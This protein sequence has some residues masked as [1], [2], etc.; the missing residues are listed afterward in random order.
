M[1]TALGTRGQP[2]GQR[3]NRAGSNLAAH[4][5]AAEVAFGENPGAQR[6]PGSQDSGVA[7][8]TSSRARL[9]VSGALPCRTA[10]TRPGEP[11]VVTDRGQFTESLFCA[12]GREEDWPHGNG[13]GMRTS[14]T[15]TPST[16]ET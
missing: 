3:P 4:T 10:P 8:T 2:A 9:L 7:L 6:T 16:G 14:S 11:I 13:T 5:S 12:P 15:A 1:N